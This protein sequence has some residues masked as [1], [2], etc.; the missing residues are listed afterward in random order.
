MLSPS[1]APDDE[2]RDF[3]TSGRHKAVG[4]D[5][6]G[7]VTQLPPLELTRAGDC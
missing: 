3:W 1:S 6:T 4:D 7:C 5:E 2:K